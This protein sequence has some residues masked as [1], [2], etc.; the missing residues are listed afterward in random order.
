MISEKKENHLYIK[1]EKNEENSFPQIII[2]LDFSSD[3]ILDL[4]SLEITNEFQISSLN[5][6]NEHIISKGFC[7][8]IALNDSPQISKIES[9]NIVLTLIEAE[10]FI[11]MEQIQRDLGI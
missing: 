7:L 2:S 3:L 10:N 5:K 8:V 1:L 4:L 9:L 11:Q 6:I